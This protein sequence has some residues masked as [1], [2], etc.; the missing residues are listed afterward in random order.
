MLGINRVSGKH[1]VLDICEFV[2]CLHRQLLT[3]WVPEASWTY[4]LADDGSSC[5]LEESYYG[6]ILSY[7]VAFIYR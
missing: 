6:C 2:Y 4:S 5:E 1:L 3:V 7:L